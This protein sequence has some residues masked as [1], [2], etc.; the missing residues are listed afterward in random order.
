MSDE[1]KI[2]EMPEPDTERPEHF[3][4][5]ADAIDESGYNDDQPTEPPA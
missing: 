4:G 3:P 2:G 1:D 5:G